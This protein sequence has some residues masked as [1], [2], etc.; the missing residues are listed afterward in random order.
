MAG[1]FTPAQRLKDIGK[2][3]FKSNNHKILTM[4]QNANKVSEAMKSSSTAAQ[5]NTANAPAQKLS[6]HQKVAK[7]GSLAG[8]SQ[9]EI[10]NYLKGMESRIAAALPKHLTADRIIQMAATTI[11]RN[12]AIAKCTPASL[13]GSIMQASILGF[14]PVD[15]LGYC[16]FVPYGKDVQFQIGYK[17]YIELARRSG[18]V[19]MVYA[20][21]VR[22]GDEFEANFGL[23]P[24]LKHKPTFDSTKPLTHVYAVCQFTDG[25]YNFVVLSK[26]DVERLR[27]RNP[28]Q[29]GSPAGAW[30]SDYEAMAKGKALKQLSKYLPLNIDTQADLA[31]DEAVLQPESF[32]AG[33]VKTEDI[34]YDDAQIVDPETGEI[35]SSEGDGKKPEDANRTTQAS[36]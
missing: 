1:H 7:T 8:L 19:K 12:P 28:M 17:G 36:K 14:P 35:M 13:L 11:H 22:E 20:E 27:M 10:G 3:N 26:S 29:K 2:H 25:G 24:D 18:R 32:T 30:A 33:R 16:Y 31:T 5:A 21:V 4:T 23:N 15:A 34:Q 6:V 9:G